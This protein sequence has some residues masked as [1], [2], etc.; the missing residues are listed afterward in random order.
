MMQT[1]V[2]VIADLLAFVG[3]VTVLRSRRHFLFRVSSHGVFE[4]KPFF[5]RSCLF[6]CR[7]AAREHLRRLVG[8]A[9]EYNCYQAPGYG[10]EDDVAR[11][12]SV[13]PDCHVYEFNDSTGDYLQWDVKPDAV[14]EAVVALC[15]FIV[16]A[17]LLVVIE[18]V[19]LAGI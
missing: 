15:L 13:N 4:E 8:E 9:E 18:V 7:K 11:S 17:V 19:L 2:L 1:V 5:E 16:A 6:L 12:T 3:F 14:A 10:G